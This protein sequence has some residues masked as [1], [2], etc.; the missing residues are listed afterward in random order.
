MLC[1]IIV[2]LLICMK[3]KIKDKQYYLLLGFIYLLYEI[4]YITVNSQNI[5][6]QDIL[7]YIIPFGICIAIG[8]EF[9]RLKNKTIIK[10]ATV[11]IAIFVIF[12]I[13][14]FYINNELVTTNSYK[15]PPRLYYLSYAIGI[16]LLAIY[17][18]EVR[19]IFNIKD[20][21]DIWIIKFI[22]T[23]TMWIYLWHI[24]YIILINCLCNQLNWIIK[25]IIIVIVSIITTYIQ[26]K[27]IKHI[28]N[29][30]IKKILDC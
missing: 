1:A 5:I 30:N 8:L 16:S 2:P 9:K 10:I 24:L 25:Y 3:E 29:D 12:T 4:L 19:N 7:Y 20:K 23:H 27:I 15:Y 21:L 17:F 11:L 14:Y 28:K 26:T 13:C 22:S 18:I 6:L